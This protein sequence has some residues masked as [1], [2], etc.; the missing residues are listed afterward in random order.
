MA[1]AP[2]KIEV[3]KCY[4]TSTGEVR[5]VTDVSND[6]VTFEVR[7]KRHTRF[8]WDRH[9]RQSLQTFASQIVEEVTS[10]SDPD[11]GPGP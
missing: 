3:N 7:A 10:H 2:E 5:R 8:P 11:F 6:E 1:V 9:P 4:R